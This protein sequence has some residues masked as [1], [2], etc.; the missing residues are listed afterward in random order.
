[1][2]LSMRD[3]HMI[4]ASRDA[5]ERAAQVFTAFFVQQ[6]SSSTLRVTDENA[7]YVVRETWRGEQ[8]ISAGVVSKHASHDEAVAECE[9]LRRE[10]TLA[11]VMTVAEVAAEY[12]LSVEAVRAAIYRG[13]LIP[14]KSGATYLIFRNDAESLWGER[15]RSV[16]D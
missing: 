5:G 6:G 3:E 11:D 4:V 2:K 13:R 9:R 10:Q 7:W 14:R 1:M 16:S 15:R 8:I 12:G